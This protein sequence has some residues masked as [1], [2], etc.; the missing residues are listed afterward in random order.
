VILLTSTTDKISLVTDFTGNV[1]VST[2]F[3]DR[4]QS[5]GNVGL[6]ERQLTTIT[7]A[8]TT[9]IVAAPGATTTRKVKELRVH[10]ANTTSPM[11]VTLQY[12]NNGTLYEYIS[13]RLMPGDAL[14]YTENTG[15]KLITQQKFFHEIR[16]M[17]PTSTVSGEVIC[18]GNNNAGQ[19]HMPGFSIKGLKSNTTYHFLFSGITISAATIGARINIGRD[20]QSSGAVIG[21]GFVA[22]TNSNTAATIVGTAD[23]YLTL[24]ALVSVGTGTLAPGGL[25]FYAGTFTTSEFGERDHVEVCLFSETS[26]QQVKMQQGAWYRVWEATGFIAGLL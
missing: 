16:V 4:N 26:N 13:S 24:S 5:S 20:Q 19:A 14:T 8:A 2:I 3:I 22:I 17:W 1:K 9:D 11:D 15:F 6:A 7:T 23:D 21:G 25:H 10:N 18:N 12:N